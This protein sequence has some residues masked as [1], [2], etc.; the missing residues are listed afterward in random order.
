MRSPGFTK[1]L[2]VVL[3]T[4]AVSSVQLA[5]ASSPARMTPVT[6]TAAPSSLRSR[7]ALP[8]SIASPPTP[9]VTNGK[10]VLADFPPGGNWDIFAVN[11]DGSGRVNLTNSP[12]AEVEPV[13]S[14]DGSKILFLKVGD[15]AWDICVMDA[16]GSHVTNLTED[17]DRTHYNHNEYPAWSPD[18][19]KIAFISF[20]DSY[21]EDT[22]LYVMNADGSG[23]VNLS[24]TPRLYEINLAW[25]PDS[26]KIAFVSDRTGPDIYVTTVDGSSLTRLTGTS[27]I[28][29]ANY[30]P[31]WSPDGSKI[32]FRSSRDPN[33]A[34]NVFLM[35]ADGS[36]QVRLT[37]NPGYDMYAAWS[38]DGSKI[39]Y[40]SSF[41]GA[42]EIFVMNADGSNQ[43]NVTNSP[44]N[45]FIPRWSPDGTQLVF[46][47]D[48]D[49][50][51]HPALFVM[52]ADGSNPVNISSNFPYQ[53]TYDW[54]RA[55]APASS[56]PGRVPN[57]MIAFESTRDGNTE[58]YVMDTTGTQ[59][60]RLTNMAGEDSQPTWGPDGNRIAFASTLS[61]GANRYDVCLVKFDGTGFV[62]LTNQQADARDPAW[63][64]DGGKIAFSNSFS[65]LSKISVVNSS[66][67]GLADLTIPSTRDSE[68]SWSPDGTKI[69]F[70]SR[71]TGNKEVYLMNADGSGQTNLTNNSAEDTALAWSPDGQRLVFV[72]KRVGG[73]PDIFVMNSDGSNVQRL[74]TTGNNTEPSW[75]P[76][77]TRIAFVSSRDTGY[78]LANGST[79]EIYVMTSDG[80][81]QTRLTTNNV[82]D[83]IPRWSPDGS[84]IGWRNRLGGLQNDEIFVMQPGGTNQTN[85]T[86][87]LSDEF[88]FS[89]G[90]RTASPASTFNTRVGAY[91]IV[92]VGDSTLIFDS[93]TT[94]GDT[95]VMPI[96]PA[97]AGA[98][99]GNYALSN[100][101]LAFEV[102]TTA[103]YTAPVTVC[104]NVPASMDQASFA[105][106]RVLHG[107]NGVL[108]DRT[109]LSPNSPSPN[110]DAKYIC[111][112]V[113]SLSPFVIASR[114]PYVINALYDQTKA[115]RSGSTIPIKLQ[116]A[117]NYGA[118]LSSASIVVSA[119][120]IVRTSTN[121]SS[122]VADA[123]DA[124]PD[125]NFRFDPQLDVTGG[126]YIFNLKTKGYASG[127]YQL[128]F[129]VGTDATTYSVQFQV[130]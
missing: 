73:F 12:E 127:T 23:L 1:R 54:G 78:Q 129:R 44:A 30:E 105:A 125:N 81:L 77:G 89:W 86:S 98:L 107:E 42:G 65:G 108:V 45:D 18:G 16:D 72:S 27:G 48:R 43:V 55:A 25:S 110:F 115:V 34:N 70:I 40:S 96:D 74:T 35:N 29:G 32:A 88:N 83:S 97:T 61:G 5:L 11:P 64:P 117:D 118:N 123:G 17:M 47:S 112:R 120:S 15:F 24:N 94:A 128:K 99:P 9:S 6:K 113:S 75:S 39:A 126:G 101:S 56:I 36:N 57:G 66:G 100:S 114:T 93:V 28:L 26:R 121:T 76:D 82:R 46:Q 104:F 79:N 50:I 2:V 111:A 14:P 52:N 103:T 69:A 124:N 38:P 20:Q 119:V 95:T 22:E 62:N 7:F 67:G 80:Q 19:T 33:G 37:Y 71:R 63:S 116:L 90:Y 41:T 106:L 68:P 92:A 122:L 109:I 85:L 8:A 51:D 130:K 87:N 3:L 53:G 21:S 49:A 58:I 60:T 13:W 59:Q 31:V 4:L 84:R 10:I 102:T 91:P